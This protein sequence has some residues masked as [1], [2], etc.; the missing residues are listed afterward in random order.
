MP[1]HIILR[2]LDIPDIAQFDVYVNHGGYQALRKA[3]KENTPDQVIDIV[4]RANLRGRGGAGFPAGVKWGFLPKGVF[5]RYLVVNADESEPGTFKDRQIMENNPHQLLEGIAITA[6]AIQC[7]AA[8]IYIRGEYAS[9]AGKLQR[10]I[11]AARAANYLGPNIL[12][13]DFTLEVYL[14]LG[15]G[16][17]ICGEETA[18]LES[19]EG[20]LGQPRN[21]PPFPAAVGLYNKPTIINN[22]ET[23]A[24]VPPIIERGPEWYLSIGTEKSP[25]PKV[26][27]LS[28]H[29][30]RP[31]NYELPLGTPFRV[32]IEEYGGGVR[33]GKQVKGILP[34][35]ASAP[36]LPAQ[37][38]DVPMDFESVQAAGSMLGSGSVIVMDEDTDMVWAALKMVRFFK[39]ESCG[40]C[41][42]C[43]EGTYW[44]LKLLERI[45]SGKAQLSDIDL[46]NEVAST[47]VG[48]CFCPLGEF[49][50]SPVLSSIKH[51]RDEYEAA[52]RAQMKMAS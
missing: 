22:V 45:H 43:R 15:A 41:T 50:V 19:L 47:M 3:I 49:S 9:V 6:Y 52:I 24:N 28:G 36:I 29:V 23:L 51:F 20:R 21:K 44:M 39:H 48:K 33:D 1:E 46:L 8:Y 13:S 14:H 34:A 11:N 7:R 25:G 5:P 40:K 27:C 4:K 16:A 38:L 37:A 17:Y 10:A 31:G 26:F 12:G 42:P 35:G 30:N 18:L 2:D 32:L